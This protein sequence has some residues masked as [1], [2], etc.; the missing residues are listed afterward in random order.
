MKS[1][2]DYLYKRPLFLSGI[3]CAV[4]SAGLF[5]FGKAVLISSV[6]LA[7]MIGFVILLRVDKRVL[8][9]LVLVFV[10]SLSA[11]ST[12]SS[13]ER[14]KR[15]IGTTFKAELV[16]CEVTYKSDGFY[17]ADVKVR[18]SDFIDKGVKLSVFYSPRKLEVGDCFTADVKLRDFNNNTFK[19]NSFSDSVYLSGSISNITPTDNS[20][21]LIKS[22]EKIRNY[23]KT[24][25]RDNLNF[26]SAATAGA[27]LFGEKDYFTDDYSLKVRKAG[28]SHVMVVSGMH[29][30]IITGL[31]LKLFKRKFFNRYLKAFIMLAVVGFLCLICGFTMSIMRA[32]VTYIIMA[33]GIAFDRYGTPENNLGGAVTAILCFSPFAIHSISFQLSVLSTFGI[34]V[35]ALPLTDKIKGKYDFNFVISYIIDSAV[36]SLSAT[37]FTLPVVIYSFGGVSIVAIISNLVISF[38]VTWALYA[39]VCAIAVNAIIPFTAFPFFYAAGV[40]LSYINFM[41]EYIGSLSFSYVSVNKNWGFAALFAIFF[42]LAVLVA[43]KKRRNMLKL[44]R[45]NEKI[46]KEGGGKLKWRI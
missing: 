17:I 29:L 45:M 28:V 19:R 31:I 16:L 41:I 5:Y 30:A 18:K 36:F 2:W 24:V 13:I 15:Y 3:I 26:S 43:C 39:T 4:L 46:V 38:A 27:L 1:V 35:I 23:I 34:L 20:D 6:I 33:V 21:F 32:G 14:T 22:A 40:I 44:K 42:A 7:F 9:A 11:Y 10:Y 37:L 25:L 12:V 8:F